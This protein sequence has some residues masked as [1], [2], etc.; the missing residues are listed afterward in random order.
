MHYR[1]TRI[2]LSLVFM[3]LLTT[4]CSKEPA[5]QSDEIILAT[6]GDKTISLSEY[7]YR[8][9]LIPRPPIFKD[10]E[11]TLSNLIAEKLVAIDAGKD[12]E[13]AKNDNFQAYIQ[14]IEEQA[15]RDQLFYLEARDKA[16]VDTS[17]MLKVYDASRYDYKVA[18]YTIKSDETAERLKAALE[19]DSTN[20]AEVFDQIGEGMQV[21]IHDVK[22]KDPDNDYIHDAL[23]SKPLKVGEVLGPIKLENNQ[24]I[25]MKIEDWT[26]HPVIGPEDQQLRLKDV[27]SKLLEK[28][29]NKL[30]RSF[31]ASV[32]AGK[33]LDF[34][35]DT[36]LKMADI[37]F[38]MFLKSQA[39]AD[40]LNQ[41]EPN[42]DNTNMLVQDLRDD[43]ALLD[44]P[45]F[46]IDD[47][48]WTVRDFKKALA[49]HPLVYRNTKFKNKT[50]YF[51]QFKYAIADL[52]RDQYLNK[53]AYDRHLQNHNYVKRRVSMWK[54]A[55]IAH[56]QVEHYIDEVAKRPDFDRARLKGSNNYVVSY[57]DSLA[58]AHKKDIHVD[59]A[60][61]DDIV[62]TKTDMM[63]LQENVPYE[64]VVP[65]FPQYVVKKELGLDVKK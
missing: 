7:K 32:M 18:F 65:S 59:K 58:T 50:E 26:F 23:Y 33:K 25:I 19:A 54:D 35:N 42:E 41:N 8:A 55:S 24:H 36:F 21:P 1:L 2:F 63:A 22:F 3:L 64:A 61:L 49:S 17:E 12:N 30:W 6:V 62:L 47:K 11:V 14:G 9:E 31:M 38:S 15:M 34:V 45:F 51:D 37:S 56:F 57:V 43:S 40:S 53:E 20:R 4:M 16:K 27:E 52:I 29:T 46:S 60:L 13:L 5:N 44:Y 39:E 48:V 10:K 28:K